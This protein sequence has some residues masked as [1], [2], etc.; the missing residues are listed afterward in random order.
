MEK[1]DYSINKISMIFQNMDKCG[2]RLTKPELDLC[3]ECTNGFLCK[4]FYSPCPAKLVYSKL[5][6]Y[7]DSGLTPEQAQEMS[8]EE[9]K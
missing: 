7:E 2:L 5:A 6:Q 9:K 1:Q 3:E 4:L 8:K